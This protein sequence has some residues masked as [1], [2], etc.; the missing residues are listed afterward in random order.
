MIEL[1]SSRGEVHIAIIDACRDNPFP[2]IKLAGNLDA[3]LFETKS[4]FEV[5]RT[6]LNSL[7]AFS[8]SP[9]MV[10]FDGDG[11]NSPYTSA[12]LKV[13]SDAPEEHAQSVFSKVRETVFQ[14]TDGKQVPWE[15]STL[16]KPFR[17]RVGNRRAAR[18]DA[19]PGHHTKLR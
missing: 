17:F 7:V 13:L 14:S 19:G 4:G 11:E 15:S 12:I 2:N 9:G 3:S 5:F 6:P 18:S 10:A 8:T 1:L 16:V